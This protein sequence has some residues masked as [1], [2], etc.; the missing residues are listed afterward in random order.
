MD[1]GKIAI[2]GLMAQTLCGSAV[3]AAVAAQGEPDRSPSGV[4]SATPVIATLLVDA[5]A[6]SPTFRRLVETIEATDGIVFVDAGQCGQSVRACLALIRKVS[7]YRQIFIRVDTRRAQGCALAESV[8]H[9]LQH[10]VEVLAN[11]RIVDYHTM[12]AFFG[13][14]GKTIENRFETKA[15]LRAGIAVYNEMRAQKAC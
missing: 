2:V 11:P 15:A 9:E 1:V 8:G 5:R 10:A 14:V 4:R 6:H 13:Q 3:S 7:D 12:A